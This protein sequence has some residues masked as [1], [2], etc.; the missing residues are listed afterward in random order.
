[1]RDTSETAWWRKT[2]QLALATL[3][4][5]CVVGVLPRLVAGLLDRRAVL[6]LPL[7]TFLAVVA[8]PLVMLIAIFAFTARQR[9]LDRGHHVSE[10]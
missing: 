7:G 6:G 10:D 4:G 5:L 2:R 1:M 3:A 9:G 8:V